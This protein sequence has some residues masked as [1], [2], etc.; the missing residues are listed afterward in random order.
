MLDDGTLN[1]VKLDSPK[2]EFE[3]IGDEAPGPRTLYVNRPLLNAGNLAAWARECGIKKLLPPGDMHVTVAFSKTPLAWADAGTG[4]SKVVA[5]GGARSVERL[6]NEGAV[7]LRF[8]CPQLERDWRRILDAGASW[9]HPGYKPHVTFTM[10]DLDVDLDKLEPYDGPLE[11]GPEEWDEIG[12]RPADWAAKAKASLIE[13]DAAFDWNESEH[14]RDAAGEF[15]S[16]RARIDRAEAWAREHDKGRKH[17]SGAIKPIGAALG[18]GGGEGQESYDG[19]QDA[20]FEEGKHPRGQPKN[21]GQFAS[22]SGGG[23]GGNN[24]IRIGL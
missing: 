19:A 23:G 24:I 20:P 4:V 10:G 22:G 5:K 2:R 6:G 21:K 18:Y 8:E 1:I 7:V 3:I 15:A 13:Y 17:H 14:D 11:F 12:T 16:G 9:D